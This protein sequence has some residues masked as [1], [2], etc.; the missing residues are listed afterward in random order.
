MNSN[1]KWTH[2]KNAIKQVT[3]KYGNKIN[4]GLYLYS[5]SCGAKK[6]SPDAAIGST[7][8][9]IMSVLNS[10]R[11]GGGTPLG[12]SIDAAS[13]MFSSSKRKYI[14][15]ITDGCG[16]QNASQLGT[17]A[18]NALNNGVKT[19]VVGFG[20]GVCPGQLNSIAQNGGVS[21]S[22]YRADNSA[23]LNAALDS[24]MK[25]TAKEDCD[26]KD[27]DCDNLVDEQ[28]P[29]ITTG[30]NK[31]LCK[32][33]VKSCQG[34][35]YV[36]IQNKIGPSAEICDGLDNNCNGVNDDGFNL[37]QTCQDGVGACKVTGKTICNSTGSGVVCNKKGG[38]PGAEKCD[39]KD[40]DCDGKFDETFKLGLPCTNGIGECKNSGKTVCSKDTS[41]TICNAIP[42]ASQKETCDNKD[43]D[44]DG[45][46]D[47]GVSRTC[48]TACGSGKELCSS[49]K[50]H[51][52]DAP[53]VFKE[54]CDGIDNDC[55]TFVDDN[56]SCA[57]AG[58]VCLCGSC[59]FPCR[60]GECPS[61]LSCNSL[62]FCVKN[63]C[64]GIACPNGGTCQKGKCVDTCKNKTCPTDS[65]CVAGKCE[66]KTCNNDSSMACAQGE[67]CN[68]QGVCEQDPCK[69]MTCNSG[70]QCHQG[71]CISLCKKS[72]CGQNQRCDKGICTTTTCGAKNCNKG[73]VCQKGLCISDPCLTLSCPNG[74]H[75]KNGN[76]LKDPCTGSSCQ[77]DETC[78]LGKCHKKSTVFSAGQ[79]GAT[80]SGATG[81]GSSGTGGT[82]GTTASSGSGQST[83][84]NTA[85]NTTAGSGGSGSTGTNSSAGSATATGSGS[86][87][88]STSNSGSGSGSG[89]GNN[90]AGSGT[91][92]N[93]TSQGGSGGSAAST[94]GNNSGGSGNTANSG[95]NT[96]ATAS[97]TGN[98]SGSGTGSD[99]NS[100]GNTGSSDGSNISGNGQTDPNAIQTEGNNESVDTAGCNLKQAETFKSTLALWSV[101]FLM[102]LSL[103]LKRRRS[104]NL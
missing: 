64:C 39:S 95:S 12:S 65:L 11:P 91:S 100:S 83:G 41:G 29:N 68:S 59:A 88:G 22:Y 86:A 20:S 26:G 85:S 1:S 82:S 42:K 34:G 97:T 27:N 102:L 60:R 98:S 6:S 96:G 24:I 48:S 25:V 87:S 70:E 62:G 79:G 55:N 50:F 7:A 15:L 63:P 84:G 31:G 23:Q 3:N 21:T 92:A 74:T 72:K 46:T 19:F 4:F 54:Q 81:S 45:K 32:P 47:N 104:I 78:I 9:R 69:N 53:K 56:A 13:N 5:G 14:L 33:E 17:T 36:T 76:C 16:C 99:G 37:G 73:Q 18:R 101:I 80:G 67:T 52:C 66:K 57:V 35:K 30:L 40:N 77:K 44:C 2:S 49:G 89:S 75:C 43:N 38:V 8:S 93:T 103:V 28:I 90:T 94:T 51:S 58:A 61:G 71:K 10:N